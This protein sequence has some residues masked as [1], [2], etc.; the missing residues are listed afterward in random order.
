EE[1]VAFSGG[2]KYILGY[3]DGGVV[4]CDQELLKLKPKSEDEG[5]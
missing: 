3:I 1:T 2:N 5:L 4:D